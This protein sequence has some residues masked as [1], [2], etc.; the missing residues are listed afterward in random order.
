MKKSHIPFHIPRFKL[1]KGHFKDNLVHISGFPC[2]FE[3]GNKDP[4]VAT[5]LHREGNS[6]GLT[7]GH[8]V[9]ERSGQVSARDPSSHREGRRLC[10]GKVPLMAG[11]DVSAQGEQ[12]GPNFP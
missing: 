4:T 11:W 7:L 6:W 9:Q 2:R 10:P 1:F 8:E 12:K 5:R 3:G